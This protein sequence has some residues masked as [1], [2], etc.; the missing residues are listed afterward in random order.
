MII[1]EFFFIFSHC[2]MFEF[3][4]MKSSIKLKTRNSIFV[5]GLPGNSVAVG[6]N[7]GIW[8]FRQYY[9]FQVF[10]IRHTVF[11]PGR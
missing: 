11:V 10:Q 2:F 8:V 7:T 4:I 3:F 1:W 9:L 6:L 5:K